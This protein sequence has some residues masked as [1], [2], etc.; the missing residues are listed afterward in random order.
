MHRYDD[1][2]TLNVLK[3]IAE[4]TG[5]TMEDVISNMGSVQLEQFEEKGYG[6]LIRSAF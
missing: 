5:M 1:A 3:T 6:P 4:V 2:E